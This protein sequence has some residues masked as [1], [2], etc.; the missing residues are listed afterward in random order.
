MQR[1]AILNKSGVVVRRNDFRYLAVAARTLQTMLILPP[2]VGAGMAV[3]DFPTGRGIQVT[4]SRG[5]RIHF[6]LVAL[7]GC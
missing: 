7:V 6:S 4:A 2:L 1:R 5:V 3:Y